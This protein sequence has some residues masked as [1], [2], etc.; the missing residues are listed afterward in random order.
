MK[1]AIGKRALAMRFGITEI[2][3]H[4]IILKVKLKRLFAVTIVGSLLLIA[5]TALPAFV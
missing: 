2:D 3:I 1:R 4:F 5:A